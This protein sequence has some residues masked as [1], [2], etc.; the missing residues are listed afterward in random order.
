MR[1]LK[2]DGFLALIFFEVRL[3]GLRMAKAAAATDIEPMIAIV[4]GTSIPAVA[5]TPAGCSH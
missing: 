3:I 2:M 5:T 4:T 1:A